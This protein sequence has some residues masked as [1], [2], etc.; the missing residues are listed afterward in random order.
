MHILGTDTELRI[1]RSFSRGDTSAMDRLY[2]EYA[3]Y[4]TGVCARYVPDVNDQKDVLQEAFIRIFTQIG[5]FEYRGKGSLKAWITRIAI[6]EALQLIRQKT[7]LHTFEAEN[8]PPDIPD[9]VPD[10]N[11]IGEHTLLCMIQ[12][13][14]TGYRAVFNLY[15]IEG[16]SHQEIA[17]QLGIKP[18]TSASQFHRARNMLAKM[19]KE[20]RIKDERK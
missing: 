4:L 3:N 14:P 8:D 2:T 11:G 20:Y 17:Q 1:V 5:T 19:I 6:N 13:L 15:A 16:K 7:R 10:T 12:R 9:D 18:D